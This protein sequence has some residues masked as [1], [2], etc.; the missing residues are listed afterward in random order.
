LKTE[1]TERNVRK[2]KQR[3]IAEGA[4]EVDGGGK[5][6]HAKFLYKGKKIIV[7]HGKNGELPIGTADGIARQ[8]GWK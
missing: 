8:A 1:K 3:L 5:G 7:P 6:S 2:I 4:L